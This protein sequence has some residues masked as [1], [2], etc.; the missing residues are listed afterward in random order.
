MKPNVLPRLDRLCRTD[1]GRA[2][3]DNISA[4]P[5]GRVGTLMNE[6]LKVLEGGKR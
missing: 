6:L 2:L 4:R 5:A 1:A 3:L